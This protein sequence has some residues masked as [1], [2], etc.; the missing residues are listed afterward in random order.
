MPSNVEAGTRRVETYWVGENV[1]SQALPFTP[2]DPD[3]NLYSNVVTSTEAEGS[4]EW[5]E[6]TGTGNYVPVVKNRQQGSHEI[7]V[8]YDLARFPVDGSGNT[9]DPIADAARRDV[10]HRVNATHTFLEVEEKNAILAENTVHHRYFDEDGN[11]HPGTDPGATALDTRIEAYG[12]GCVPEEATMTIDPSD[13]SVVTVELSYV[14]HKFRRYQIDQ[15]DSEYIHVRSTDSSDTSAT[16][17]IETADGGT[18]ESLTLDGTDAT[19]SVSSS[20][21]YDSLRVSMPSDISGT[22]EVYGDDGS[23]GGSAGAPNQLLAVIHGKSDYDN[24]EGDTGVPL[25]GSG[26]FEDDSAFGDGIPA[27]GSNL[28]FSSNPAAEKVSSTTITVS[29][30]ISENATDSGLVQDIRASTQEITAESTVFGE[31]ESPEK[32][33]DHLLGNEAAV[34]FTVEGGDIE[35]PRAYV[36]DGG[37]TE[38]EEGSA[39]MQVEVTWSALMPTDGSDPLKFTSA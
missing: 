22:L 11:S 21:T 26:S 24:I 35:L 18:S 23:G 28:N 29:N 2:Q 38:R 25:V 3:F 4:A 32:Y 37:S 1:N 15:P 10:D 17:D 36:R 31:T 6:R 7:S 5:D 12:R 27:L 30:E 16:V 20:S 14:A 33:A 19:T 34:K 13:S 9:V 39:V 8:S